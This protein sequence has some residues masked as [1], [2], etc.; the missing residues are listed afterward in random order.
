MNIALL[1]GIVNNNPEVSLSKKSGK[2][3][4][5][6]G[7]DVGK[8]HNTQ[9]IRCVAYDDLAEKVYLACAKGVLVQVVGRLQASQTQTVTITGFQ[10]L[11]VEK[12]YIAPTSDLYESREIYNE[13]KV[14]YKK[15]KKGQ[16][17]A[18][19]LW[20]GKKNEKN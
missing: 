6:L 3:Y 15:K 8:S 10:V 13:E 17:F 2:R 1:T 19:K 5:F 7:V 18:T 20:E 14:E 4:C 16:D 11:A 9:S 12:N